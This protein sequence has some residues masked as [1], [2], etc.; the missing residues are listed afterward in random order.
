M[1]LKDVNLV[2]AAPY[3]EIQVVWPPYSSAAMLAITTFPF[4]AVISLADP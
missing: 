3:F 2:H 1:K 4:L